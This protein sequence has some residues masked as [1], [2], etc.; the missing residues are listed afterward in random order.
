MNLPS[1]TGPYDLF[2][3]YRHLDKERVR[4][5]VEVVQ[6]KLKIWID[7]GEIQDFEGITNA[8]VQG[9]AYS[10]ALLAWYSADYPKSRA[11]QW[12]LTA[13]FIAAQQA[14][15]PQDV[16]TAELLG[17][18]ARYDYERG[19]YRAAEQAD[20]KQYQIYR[21]LQSEEHSDT[22][23][24]MN[25]LAATLWAQG[26]LAGARAL[27]EQVLAIRRQV[28][29]EEHPDTSI[30][31]WNL[32]VTLVQ[33]EDLTAAKDIFAKDLRWLLDRDPAKMGDVQRQIREM[34]VESLRNLGAV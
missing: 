14:G 20:R 8:I 33:L 21:A 30:S 31:A 26:E 29:G 1:D 12:E 3:S 7:E 34:F 28:L 23:G 17:W 27:H 16:E 13:A 19:D 10:K 15:D 25:D 4:P 2:I 18:V 6:K 9:L 24:S 32:F 11:C 5:L 22:L